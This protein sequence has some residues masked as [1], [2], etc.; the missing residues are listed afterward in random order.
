MYFE[1]NHGTITM[2]VKKKK[3]QQHY[4]HGWVKRG[5]KLPLK[6]AFTFKLLTYLDG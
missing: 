6:C 2:H 1:E 5:K 3:Q 4:H